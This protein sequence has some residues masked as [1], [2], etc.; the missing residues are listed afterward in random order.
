MS[1][2]NKIIRNI[3]KQMECISTVCDTNCH[4]C[5]NRL[6]DMEELEML[7]VAVKSLTAWK[8]IINDIKEYEKCVNMSN[9]DIRCKRCNDT[10][11][12]SIYN[13]ISKY[14]DLIE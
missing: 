5:E 13:I 4:E 12:S 2:V 1:D 11:F 7:T 3:Y 6:T 10:C 8:K 14:S 9:D